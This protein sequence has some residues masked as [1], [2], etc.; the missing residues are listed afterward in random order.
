[1][2]EENISKVRE[3]DVKAVP[4]WVLRALSIFF[5][6]ILSLDICNLGLDHGA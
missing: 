2:T 5:V 6:Y 4:I 1:M 3:I